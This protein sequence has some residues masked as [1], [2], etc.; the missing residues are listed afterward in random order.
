MIGS[1]SHA[2][3]AVKPGRIFLRRLIDLSS[4]VKELHHFT[5]L[6]RDA[7]SDIAWWARLIS[8]WNGQGLLAAE[9][10]L[11]PSIAVRSDASGSWGCGAVLDSSWIQLQWLSTWRDIPIAPKK[12]VPVVLAA[13][14]FAKQLSGRQ[15]LFE[16]DYT[17][18]IT[19]VRR[20]SCRVPI[21]VH[22]LRTLH[23]VA[24]HYGFTF[25]AAH[26]PVSDNALADAISRNCTN[27]SSVCAQ[28]NSRPL[29]LTP[30]VV[31]LVL[32]LQVDWTSE[33]WNKRF[34]TSLEPV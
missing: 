13:I 7:R 23:F 28:L 21:V 11:L 1:L 32:D 9:G 22:L 19:A 27:V 25:N 12:M 20:G 16:S 31:D 30:V 4:T 29:P 15:V 3:T 18:V 17:T 24:A 5:R 26:R 34:Q 14:A 33:C 8:Q 6:N 10:R 2:V